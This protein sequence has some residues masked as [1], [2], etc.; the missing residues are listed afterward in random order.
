MSDLGRINLY[1][2]ILGWEWYSDINTCRLFIHMLLKANW[3]EGKFK[4]TTVPRG[5]FVSSISKLA[6]ETRLTN[7]EIRT[8]ISH[9]IE[10]NEITKQST[11][12]YTV[13]T[14]VNYN[15]YQ[16]TPEQEHKQ[17]TSSAQTIPEPFPTIEKYKEGKNIKLNNIITKDD[18]IICPE[19]E[20]SAPNLSGIQ[21]VLNDKTFYDVPLDKIAIWKEAYPAVD[22]MRELQKMRAWLDSNSTRRKTRRGIERFINNWLSKSQDSGVRP[23]VRG[24]DTY[25]ASKEDGRSFA[26]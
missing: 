10:T 11:N 6:E 3:R 1:R 18:N 24:G 20:K 4:G 14:V 26:L 13:F 5:S 22:V 17:D 23:I 15:L 21:L 25:N 9:L 7:D 12:K 16:Y 19:P 8:A 2:K